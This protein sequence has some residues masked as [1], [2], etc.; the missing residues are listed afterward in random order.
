MCEWSPLGS[1]DLFQNLIFKLQRICIVSGKFLKLPVDRW[2]ICVSCCLCLPIALATFP[3]ISYLVNS[4]HCVG[5]KQRQN[6]N[7]VNAAQCNVVSP[8]YGDLPALA[9]GALVLVRPL[10]QCLPFYNERQFNSLDLSANFWSLHIV[11]PVCFCSSP[12]WNLLLFFVWQRF[13]IASSR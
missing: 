8:H 9:L 3:F 13:V 10:G 7:A 6:G 2:P 4:R 12:K 5:H 11:C 1:L